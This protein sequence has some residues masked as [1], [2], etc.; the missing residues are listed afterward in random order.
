ML[1]ELLSG[2]SPVRAWPTQRPK[3]RRTAHAR[4]AAQG[5]A[6]HDDRARPAPDTPEPAALDGVLWQQRSRQVDQAVDAE[7]RRRREAAVPELPAPP[8]RLGAGLRRHSRL[9][10]PDDDQTE[11][12]ASHPDVSA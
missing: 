9:I 6:A 1:L 3:K 10:L 7:R 2:A 4:E 11:S 5:T 12:S 8:A